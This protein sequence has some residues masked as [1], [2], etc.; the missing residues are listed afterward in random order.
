MIKL[1]IEE[2]PTQVQP[3]E[4]SKD[5]FDVPTTEVPEGNNKYYK[6]KKQQMNKK[7]MEQ[8]KN[9]KKYLSQMEIKIVIYSND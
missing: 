6:Q 1:E 8:K 9:Y 2:V 4:P 5:S 7:E 3:E